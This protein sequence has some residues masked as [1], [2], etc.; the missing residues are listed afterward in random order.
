MRD[1][2]HVR[3]AILRSGVPPLVMDRG[4]VILRFTVTGVVEV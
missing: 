1:R 4:V 2:A 3:Q